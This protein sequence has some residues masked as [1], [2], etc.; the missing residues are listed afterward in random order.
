LFFVV[1]LF[2]GCWKE[3]SPPLERTIAAQTSTMYVRPCQRPQLKADLAATQAVCSVPEA[4]IKNQQ[5]A[6]MQVIS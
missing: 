5:N 4:D 3:L 1:E 6:N 2:W